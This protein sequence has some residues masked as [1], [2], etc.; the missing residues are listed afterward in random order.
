MTDHSNNDDFY[1]FD[2]LFFFSSK[3]KKIVQTYVLTL[4]YNLKI[5]LSNF[6]I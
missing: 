2:I 5:L 3:S 6:E 4:F 1:P